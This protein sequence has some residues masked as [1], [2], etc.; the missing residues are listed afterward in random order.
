VYRTTK[1]FK[2]VGKIHQ[3]LDTFRMPVDVRVETQGNPVDKTIMVNGTST[4]F[5]VDTFGSPTPGGISIDPDNNLL[6][7]TPQLRVRAIVA[8]GE[9]Y[10]AAGKYYE[11]VQQYQRALEIKPNYSL[12]HFREGEAMFYQKNYQA[13]ANAFR[14]ALGGD[15]DPK[16]TAVWS[17]IYIGKIYDLLGQRERAVN[18]YTL[19]EHTHDNTAGAQAEATTYIKKPYK[20][21]NVAP[22]TST[23]KASVPATPAAKGNSSQSNGPVLKRRTDDN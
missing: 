9:S 3:P 2:V 21:D 12:A 5:E 15:L 10:A 1:G 18:E 23:G 16:W 4:E 7:S 6:K 22:P 19:A 17:H 20:G 13:A 11:A 14:A 8:R